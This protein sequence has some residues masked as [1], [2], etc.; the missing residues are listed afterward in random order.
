MEA[1]QEKRA[2][3]FRDNKEYRIQKAS[4]QSL[5]FE[6]IDMRKESKAYQE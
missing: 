2:E 3:V 5:A 6:F 4:L 1:D